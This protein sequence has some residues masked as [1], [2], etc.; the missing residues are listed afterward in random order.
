MMPDTVAAGLPVFD[1]GG[2]DE[3]GKIALELFFDGGRYCGWQVQHNAVSVQQRLQDALEA[4]LGFRPDVCGCS[5]TDA[6][7]HAN[8]YVCHIDAKGV[9][10]PL[11]KLPL[12]VNAHLRGEGIVVKKAAAADKDFHARYSC[13]G[14][15]YVYLLWNAPYDN[16]FLRGRCF[17]YP[18]AVDETKLDFFGAELVGRHD[19]KSFMAK[20]SKIVEDT[21]RTVY[22]FSVTRE[23]ELLTLRV[24]ADGFLYN[25]VRIITGTYLAAAAGR[26]GKGDISRVIR[27]KDRRAAGDTAPACGL[28]LNKVYYPMGGKTTWQENF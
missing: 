25:M 28:Y 9:T 19:F 23:N 5:R 2:M 6:G 8:S 10:I 24:S 4:A 14:K 22:D 1:A 11:G 7:V 15:E 13:A 17:H 21:V 26:Y 18:I 27:A 12:A 16:P 3:D 20:G